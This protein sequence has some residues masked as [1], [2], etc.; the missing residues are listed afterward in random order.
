M[1]VFCSVHPIYAF[2]LWQEV[3]KVYRC[4]EIDIDGIFKSILL[5]RKKKYAALMLKDLA[6]RQQW[7][8]PLSHPSPF[9]MDSPS[10][11]NLY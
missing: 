7:A 6:P 4:L 1:F 10:S 2:P 8:G 3:N 11:S 9:G 5:L